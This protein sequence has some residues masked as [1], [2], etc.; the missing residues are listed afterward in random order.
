MIRTGH[1][2]EQPLQGKVMQGIQA[3]HGGDLPGIMAVGY[4]FRWRREVYAVEA[5]ESHRRAAH[6]EMHGLGAHF[7]QLGN[8][9]A[10]GRSADD[11]IIHDAQAPAPY[12][13]A[14]RIDL[15]PHAILAH[16]L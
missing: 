13:G 12:H 8:A 10:Y 5:R 2:I 15:H 4:E 14:H 11:G 9:R 6:A 3:K 16:A 7:P 1:G